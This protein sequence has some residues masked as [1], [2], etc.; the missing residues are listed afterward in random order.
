MD[1]QLRFTGTKRP[2]LCCVVWLR[3]EREE[4]EVDRLSRRTAEE[5]WTFSDYLREQK[6]VPRFSLQASAFCGLVLAE[7]KVKV[8]GLIQTV[9]QEAW[10]VS[11]GLREQKTA[12]RYLLI[13]GGGGGG[14]LGGSN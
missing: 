4:S 11:A 2:V 14:T 12:L 9:T 7:R 3:L 8:D 6:K 1:I 10:T 5:A 13:T